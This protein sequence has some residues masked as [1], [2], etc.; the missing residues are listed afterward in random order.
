M[1]GN[2]P[3]PPSRR[4]SYDRDGSIAVYVDLNSGVATQQAQTVLDGLNDDSTSIGINFSDNPYSATFGIIFPELRDLAAFFIATQ[5]TGIGAMNWSANTTTLIDG[6]WANVYPSSTPY[7]DNVFSPQYRQNITP[8]NQ[9]GVKAIRW[10]MSGG[11]NAGFPRWRTLHLYGTIPAA[12]SPDRLVFWHPTSDIPLLDSVMDF[13]ESAR[14][15]SAVK[16]FR[17]KNNSPGLTATGVNLAFQ[18]NP[19]ASP[20]L[21]GQF[22]FS[23]DGAAYANTLN[24]GVLTPGQISGLLYVKRI[25]SLTA[26]LSLFSPRILA[27]YSAFL[28]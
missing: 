26:Q 21:V 14:G 9:T 6:T 7:V 2:Y 18:V 24:V 22:Q 3:D 4:M 8:W 12:Q 10:N 5:Y 11:Y 13:A 15:T 19:D 16:T 27:G 23:A 28:P 17:I 20:T 1:A 25:T